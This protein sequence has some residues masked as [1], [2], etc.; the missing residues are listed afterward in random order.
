LNTENRINLLVVTAITTLLMYIPF[1]VYTVFTLT[2]SLFYSVPPFAF[3]YQRDANNVKNGILTYRE[4][5]AVE[6]S[7]LLDTTP[8]EIS[9]VVRTNEHTLR[10]YNLFVNDDTNVIHFSELVMIDE[11]ELLKPH[12]SDIQ[13]LVT[14]LVSDNSQRDHYK[15]D[16][17]AFTLDYTNEIINYSKQNGSVS[18]I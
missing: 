1:K 10:F 3:L 13:E 5:T 6:I 2:T 15:T 12:A 14:E 7:Q 8:E 16:L 17:F 9:A 18:C 4:V 11:C